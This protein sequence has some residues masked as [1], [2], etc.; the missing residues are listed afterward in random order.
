MISVHAES[1]R[2]GVKALTAEANHRGQRPAIATT[3]SLA[4]IEALMSVALG[5]GW[6]GRFD[7]IVAGDKRAT[8][9]ADCAYALPDDHEPRNIAMDKHAQSVR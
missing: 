8:M 2:P 9:C 5:E 7:A 4:N 3:T 1:A 6:A